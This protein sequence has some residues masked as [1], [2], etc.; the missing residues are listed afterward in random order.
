MMQN[1]NNFHP[2]TESVADPKQKQNKKKKKQ[3]QKIPEDSELQS[4]YQEKLRARIFG[5]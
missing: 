2:Q 4:A 1:Y 3:K 5:V